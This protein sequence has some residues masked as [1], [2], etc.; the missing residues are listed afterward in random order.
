MV[1]MG[2]IVVS[3]IESIDGKMDISSERKLIM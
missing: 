3:F 1:L 2:G